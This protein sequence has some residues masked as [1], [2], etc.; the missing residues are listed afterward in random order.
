MWLRFAAA[1]AAYHLQI[2]EQVPTLGKRICASL[3]FTIPWLLGMSGLDRITN[4]RWDSPLAFALGGV[5][6][7]VGGVLTSSLWSP[8]QS[9]GIEI[10]DFGIRTSWN[11]KPL[12]RVRST[13][14]RYVRERRGIWGIKLVVSEQ[15]S[16]RKRFFSGSR[17]ALPKRLF[18][19]E[20][21]EQI[22]AQ[23]LSWLQDSE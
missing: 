22:R 15:S 6:C 2:A 3:G 8:A 14:V 13:K 9:I 16:F 1:M 23:A 19:Q 21:Y 5:I 4:G 10:D 12:R 11:G 7:F 18:K 20:E 17:V